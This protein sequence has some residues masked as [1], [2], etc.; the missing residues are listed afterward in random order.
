M[1]SA[2]DSSGD[3]ELPERHDPLYLFFDNDFLQGIEYIYSN[4]NIFYF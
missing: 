3:Y 4:I 2:I 1:R